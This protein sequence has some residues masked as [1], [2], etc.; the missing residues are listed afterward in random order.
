MSTGCMTPRIAAMVGGAMGA[1]ILAACSLRVGLQLSQTLLPGLAVIIAGALIPW[2]YVRATMKPEAK[3]SAPMGAT[4]S[5][6]DA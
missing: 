4:A 3:P 6:T 1:G 5:T 2:V